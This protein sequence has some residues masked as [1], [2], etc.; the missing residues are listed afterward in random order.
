M[1]F[2]LENKLRNRVPFWREQSAPPGKNRL[3]K[4][5]E[6]YIAY[7]IE[8]YCTSSA[9]GCIQVIRLSRTYLQRVDRFIFA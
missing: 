8:H 3:V 9:L 5:D 4:W 6:T 7:Y 2:C 1:R